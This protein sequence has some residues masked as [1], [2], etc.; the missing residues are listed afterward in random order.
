MVYLRF[1]V[2]AFGASYNQLKV[3]TGF[4]LVESP[5]F[6]NELFVFRNREI[7]CN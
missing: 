4:S 5:R 6:L 2:L 7:V 1:F 3:K